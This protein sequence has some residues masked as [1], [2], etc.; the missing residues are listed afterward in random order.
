LNLRSQLQ[1]KDKRI[2]ELLKEFNKE[3][4]KLAYTAQ[5]K[6]LHFF[7]TGTITEAFQFDLFDNYDALVSEFVSKYA[8][9]VTFTADI[10]KEI[11]YKFALTEDAINKL[12]AIQALDHRKFLNM[13]A[14]YTIDLQLFA[15]RSELEGKSLDEV[16]Q[17]TFEQLSAFKRNITAEAQTGIAIADAMIKKDFYEQAGIEKFVY[18]GPYD[19]KTR[20]DCEHTLLS[21]KQKTGWTMADIS[22][23]KTPFIERGG[24]NCRHEWVAYTGEDFSAKKE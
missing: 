15:L 22:S 24:W 23:S 11:G 8:E 6:I 14:D 21:D 16:K 9:V 13:A 18:L 17:G 12:E 2:Q 20:S 10:A 1:K 4:D 7:R 5:K 19:N 3:F